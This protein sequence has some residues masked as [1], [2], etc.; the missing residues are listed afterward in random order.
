MQGIC[1]NAREMLQQDF[2]GDSGGEPMVVIGGGSKSNFWL[3]ILANVLNR[4]IRRGEGDILLGAA[5][6][7]RP[8]IKPPTPTPGAI[9]LPDPGFVTQYE[10]VFRAWLNQRAAKSVVTS[11]KP[12][13][14][15]RSLA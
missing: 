14:H 4:A 3:Q 2:E 7:A 11:T 1:F 13:G 5:M 8:V 12:Q 6:M 9:T 10:N 15:H